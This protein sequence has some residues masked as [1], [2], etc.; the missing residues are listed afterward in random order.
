MGKIL[1]MWSLFSVFLCR[2]FP[3]QAGRLWLKWECFLIELRTLSFK[4]KV[5]K[6]HFLTFALIV[7]VTS[8]TL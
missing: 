3:F 1:H 2:F 7:F 8:F 6:V 4:L 5:E